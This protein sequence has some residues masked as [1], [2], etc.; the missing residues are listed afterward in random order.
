MVIEK[1]PALKQKKFELD[2]REAIKKKG[3]AN[4]SNVVDEPIVSSSEDD[5]SMKGRSKDVSS[6]IDSLCDW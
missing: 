4:V 6:H 2:I 5:L 3:S 1:V